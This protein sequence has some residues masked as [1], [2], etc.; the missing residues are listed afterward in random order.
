M[1]IN[2]ARFHRTNVVDSCSAW[3]VLSSLLLWSRALLA[4]CSFSCTQF[5]LYE[6]IYKRRSVPTPEDAELRRRMQR[7]IDAQ[8]IVLV[9]LDL[10]DLQD[11]EVLAARRN[12]SKGELSAI[13]F[14]RRTEQAIL[15]DDQKA[16]RLAE[17]AMPRE[18]VQTVP[19]LAGWLL[20]EGYI[21]ESEFDQL[22]GE[23][24]AF[25]RPLRPHFQAARVLSLQAKLAAQFG[26]GSAT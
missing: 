25:G 3:N 11:V 1:P 24:E 16:R 4:A 6:C 22:I 5:V 8:H 15:T 26:A 19:H 13:A 10:E 14:A 21:A 17:S 18:R 23:H 9:R 12:L 20:Y 2:P 7:E